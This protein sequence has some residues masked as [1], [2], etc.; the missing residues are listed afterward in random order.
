MSH[1]WEKVLARSRKGER[2]LGVLLAIYSTFL[3][4]L[5]F[6]NASMQE[7]DN[8]PSLP[9]R[10]AGYCMPKIGWIFVIGIVISIAFVGCYILAGIS[11]KIFERVGEGYPCIMSMLKAA[12]SALT[13]GRFVKSSTQLILYRAKKEKKLVAFAGTH[14]LV[15]DEQTFR[16]S[17]D[18]ENQRESLPG[19]C[20]RRNIG[21]QEDRDARCSPYRSRANHSWAKTL[22][23]LP[24][25]V[26]NQDSSPWGVVYILS[27]N[28]LSAQLSKDIIAKLNDSGGFIMSLESLLER[29]R[30]GHIFNLAR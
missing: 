7:V 8:D 4:S 9:Q 23:A 28:S 1:R 16:L 25:I 21:M 3:G 27:D 24:V 5:S 13:E 20:W 17:R 19:E 11:R 12:H 26:S 18:H 15:S 30:R 10:I 6:V 2:V 14:G 22:I 29:Q